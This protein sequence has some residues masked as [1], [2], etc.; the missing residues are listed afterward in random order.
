LHDNQA[1]VEAV[2]SSDSIVAVYVFDTRVFMGTTRYGFKK[3]GVHRARFIIEAVEAL[4]KDLRERGAELIVRVGHPEE[5]IYEL[6]RELKTS[7]V[8]CNRERTSQEVFVQDQLEKKLWSIGQEMRFERGK[9]LLY[10]Q[11][12]PFPITHAPDQ[13]AVFKKETEHFV[14]IRIPFEIPEIKVSDSGIDSGII[15]DLS[16][17]G[18]ENTGMSEDVEFFRGGEKTGLLRLDNYLSRL[19]ENTD[20]EH[21]MCSHLSPWISQGCLSPKTIYHYVTRDSNF[22]FF[23]SSSPLVHSLLWRDYYRLMGKKYKELVFLKGGPQQINM[24]KLD[25]DLEQAVSWLEAKTGVPIIDACMS[26]LRLTGYVEHKGRVLLANYLVHEMGVN[27]LIG[28]ELFE[29]LLLDYDPCSNY[30]NWNHIAGVGVDTTREK[31]ISFAS[32]EK[33]LDPDGSYTERW[34]SMANAIHH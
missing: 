22:E 19:S 6:A 28:A 14:R 12:L 32:Q 10:T 25:D 29:S 21:Y 33:K 34:L 24:L 20:G 4:R 1:L 3:T 9:M 30:G 7:W 17:F 8:F 5:I 15:P 11:D 27:W 2:R 16:D 23:N 18:H 26:Q 13:F 31:V